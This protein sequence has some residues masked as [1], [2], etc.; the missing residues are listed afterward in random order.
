ML[1]S[2]VVRVTS[3]CVYRRRLVIAV[4]ATVALAAAV[5]AGTHFKINTDTER[6]LPADLPWQQN[7]RGYALLFPPHQLLAVVD[8]PTPELAEI[9]SDRLAERLRQQPQLFPGVAQAEGGALMAHSALLYQPTDQV[10]QTLHRLEAMRPVLGIF[11]ADP[12]LRGVMHVVS[13]EANAVQNQRMPAESLVKPLNTL[14]DTIESLLAGKFASISGSAILAPPAGGSPGTEQFIEIDPKLDFNALRPAQAASE[15]IRKAVADLHLQ[16]D[17]GATVRLTGQA[18]INDAQFSALGENAIPGL[19][20]TM[21]AV[22][23]ILWLGLRSLRIIG[24]VLLTLAAGFAVTTAAGLLFVGAFNLLSVA[25]AVLF[26]GIGADFAIQYSVR[27]RAERHQRDDALQAIIDAAHRAGG[28]LALAAASTAIGFFSFLPTQYR[29]IAELGEIA[30]IGILVAFAGTITLLPALLASFDPP[31]EPASMGFVALAPM[32]R[33]LARHRIAVVVGTLA[34]V[35]AALPVLARIKFDFD[36]IH[37]QN[38]NSEAVETF[39]QLAGN[40]ALGIDA[41]NVLAPS[42]ATIEGV[43]QRFAVLPEIAGTRSVLDLIPHDQ[44]AKLDAIRHTE[45]ALAPALNTAPAPAPSD[46]DDAAA[47]FEAAADLQALSHTASG[48]TA[49]SAQRLAQRLGQLADGDAALRQRAEVAIALPLRHDLD[50]LRAMLQPQRLTVATL[51]RDLKS[52]WVAPDGRA[53]IELL[54]RGDTGNSAT[55]QKFAEAVLAVTPDAAG[56]P[57]ALYEAKRTVLRAFFEAGALAILGIAG[58]LWIVL[59]RFTDVLLTLVPL[60]VAAAV[61]LELMAATGQPINFANV[62]ALP[63]LLGVGVAFKI[64]YVMAWREGRT[65]LLQSTLTRAVWFSAMTTATAFGSLWLSSQPGMSSMGG[66]MALALVCTLSAAVL[67]QP[68]LMGPPRAV[69]REPV[70]EPRPEPIVA[71]EPQPREPAPVP[72]I[73]AD[74]AAARPQLRDP[75]PR[76]QIRRAGGGRG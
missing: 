3:Y 14:S 64:Y 57:I 61:T 16:Q 39:H 74:E 17:F 31:R 1:T 34:V 20:G 48:D 22:L 21:V 37:L 66:L 73:F 15:A 63:L 75:R 70:P 46:S 27:Y 6:L 5:Y 45:V 29:G 65:N 30:G 71:A 12:S 60:L 50:Q 36:P 43:A 40:P 32:D 38:Q 62:I 72:R 41:V 53:R 11:A 58:L 28:P 69:R 18:A 68:A 42:V 35:V 23:A 19:L 2:L 33:F 9:A 25:F 56:S 44:E 13:A 47:A 4:A 55:L 59:R 26:I 51:P 24:P 67:F 54:P 7:Q 76:P 49:A 8:A 10:Q 52:N